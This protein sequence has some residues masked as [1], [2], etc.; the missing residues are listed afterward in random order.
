M[1]QVTCMSWPH[2]CMTGTVV[3]SASV[4]GHRAG[5]GQAG[6]LRDRQRVHVGAQHDGG[7]LTAPQQADDAGLSDA[8]G[9]LEP[10]GSQP[11]GRDAGGSGLLG[12]E[13]SG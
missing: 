8:G 7:A 1:S 9:D 12:I 5:V 11:L 4:A 13:S 6:G 3:P 10:C 2:A